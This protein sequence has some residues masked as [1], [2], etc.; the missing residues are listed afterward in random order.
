MIEYRTLRQDVTVWPDDDKAIRALDTFLEQVTPG[1]I[2]ILEGG[3]LDF[4]DSD[5][6]GMDFA[7]AE[8]TSAILDRT[9]FPGTYLSR[10]WLIDARLCGTD[11]STANLRKADMHGCGAR[12]S[13]FVQA[14]LNRTDLSDADL[15]GADIHDTN[16][17]QAF[18]HATDLRGA[19]LHASSLGAYPKN[20]NLANAKLGGANVE[21]MAGD[22]SHPVDVGINKSRILVGAELQRWFVDAGAPD[23]SVLDESRPQA[24]RADR[25]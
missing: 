5:L 14:Q 11:F 6:S 1:N 24:S 4:S 15:R 17:N 10:A 3:G 12:E 18:L 16:L 23:V 2:P 7:G 19:D 22:V 25:R 21:N 9:R 20:A 13:I 8:W